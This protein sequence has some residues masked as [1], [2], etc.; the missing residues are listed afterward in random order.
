MGK[1]GKGLTLAFFLFISFICHAEEATETTLFN[2]QEF[3]LIA[4]LDWRDES[5]RRFM[6]DVEINRRRVFNLTARQR[7]N[8]R[9]N[10]HTVVESLTMYRYILV[11]G[12]TIFTLAARSNIPYSSL[13][14]LNRISH[15]SMI[16]P[17]KMF[18][19]PT[20]PGLF[21]PQE[22]QSD[23]EALLA[24]SNLPSSE[25]ESALLAIG[26]TGQGSSVFYFFPGREYNPTQRAFF[27]NTGFR[28]PLRTI[29]ITSGFGMRRNPI[30][31]NM[32]MH[33]GIDL[34][35]P[36]GSEVFAAGNG[37]VTEIGNDPV[38]G[39]FI[40]IRHPNNWASIYGHLQG[41]ATTLHATVQS[42]TL[43]GW[44]GST[45]Q[46]T[47]PHLHFELR[48]NGRARDPDRYLFMPGRR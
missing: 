10:I 15:P 24:S 43:I 28:F 44:V 42:G 29:R 25:E 23:L 39:I 16:E 8:H 40:V 19:L 33:E 3:P 31:G 13:A 18:L 6:T 26:E 35:A 14:S 32:R 5:F 1:Y 34:A 20:A 30:T 9:E 2:T 47:G 4:R 11:E 37:V 27:L 22:P 21:V 46:S 38:L 36:A 41:V 17:G 12:D 7:S 48:Q 45:G